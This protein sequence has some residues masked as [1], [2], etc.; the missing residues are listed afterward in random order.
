MGYE[1]GSGDTTDVLF[2]SD[3]VHDENRVCGAF[4]NCDWEA[5]SREVYASREENEAHYNAEKTFAN[6]TNDEIYSEYS[7]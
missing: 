2:E 3:M 7:T 6:E 4:R 1:G 5:C